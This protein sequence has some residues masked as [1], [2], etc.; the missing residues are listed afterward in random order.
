MDLDMPVLDGLTLCR[1][2]RGDPMLCDIPVMIISGDLVPADP[3]PSQAGACGMVLKPFTP[4]E[5]LEAVQ[6]MLARGAH[7][8]RDGTGCVPVSAGYSYRIEDGHPELDRDG[9]RGAAG[10]G[11]SPCSA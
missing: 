8:H 6:D 10:G 11:L 5:V 3:R 1:A 4:M 7:A 9:Q 2:L